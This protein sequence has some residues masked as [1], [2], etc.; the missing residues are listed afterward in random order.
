MMAAARRRS[1]PPP[2]HVRMFEVVLYGH[3]Q[4]PDV[5]LPRLRPESA[6]EKLEESAQRQGYKLRAIQVEKV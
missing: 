6:L 2:P 5:K 4:K 3:P 1:L